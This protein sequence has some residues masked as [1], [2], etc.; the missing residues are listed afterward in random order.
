MI[1]RREF[2]AALLMM[3]F[4]V[5]VSTGCEFIVWNP[6]ILGAP[7]PWR[8]FSKMQQRYNKRISLTEFS[9][10]HNTQPKR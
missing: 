10:G 1:D 8:V 6:I 2:F 9:Y 7:N 5:R 4:G 3:L